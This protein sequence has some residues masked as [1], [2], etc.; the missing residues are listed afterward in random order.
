[1]SGKKVSYVGVTKQ[2]IPQD[3]V[4]YF[5]WESKLLCHWK[6]SY[7]PLGLEWLISATKATSIKMSATMSAD[8]LY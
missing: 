4:S 8:V 6:A 2:L 5:F 7:F 3:K 1:M